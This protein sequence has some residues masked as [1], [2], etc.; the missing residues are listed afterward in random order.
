MKLK[1]LFLR[2]CS[3]IFSSICALTLLT[4]CNAKAFSSATHRY[5]TET[6]IKTISNINQDIRFDEYERSVISDYSLKPDEDEIEGAY[7]LHF[8]NPVNEKNFMGEKKSAS[9]KC[10]EHFSEAIKHFKC[11]DKIMALQELGR[12]IHFMEDLNTPVHTG[13]SKPVDAVLMF[14]LHIRFEKICD[15]ICEE[16]KSDIKSENLKYYEENELSDISKNS[17]SVSGD[18]YWYLT[19]ETGITDKEVA[20]NAVSNA[21][22]NVSGIIHKFH[23]SVS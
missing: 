15:D 6:S 20:K 17:A 5:V 2:R 22:N 11:G 12:A 7:K 10:D 3:K 14:P 18:N 21:L 1:K 13:Y 9:S 19:N 4:F 16:C 8:F 23:T